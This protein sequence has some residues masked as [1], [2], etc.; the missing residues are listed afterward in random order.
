[1]IAIKG[2]KIGEFQGGKNLSLVASS[3]LQ[4]DPDIPQAHKY[5][6]LTENPY[7][8]EIKKYILTILIIIIFRLRGW[9]KTVGA[10]EESRSLSRSVGGGGNMNGPWST[11]KEAEEQRF[12]HPDMPNMFITKA[13]VNLIRSENSLYKACPAEGCKKKVVDQ[14]NGM[15]KCEKCQREYPN[16][17]YRLL[18]SVSITNF[19]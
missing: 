4:V 8:Y 10:T 9:F 18:A 19:L 12:G 6:I 13:T 16:F 3:M 14:S 2:A 7:L 17:T 5:V 1:M 15:Y 11:F